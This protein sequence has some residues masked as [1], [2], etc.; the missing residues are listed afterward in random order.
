MNR[1]GQ[2][3]TTPRFRPPVVAAGDGCGL[4]TPQTPPLPAEMER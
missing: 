4:R 1:N 3:N 2:R